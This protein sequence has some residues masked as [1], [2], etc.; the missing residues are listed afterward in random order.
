MDLTN[1]VAVVTGA[2]RGLGRQ[3][4]LQLLER[5]AKVYAAAR[6]PE[7]IDVPGAIPLRID[8]TDPATIEAATKTAAD[9]TLVVNNAAASTKEQL[10]TGD[11]DALRLEME[12]NY[13]GTLSMVRAFVPAIERNGG[14][15]ILNILSALSW[16]H[17]A[18]DGQTGGSGPAVWAGPAVARR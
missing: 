18:S 14:G 9:A 12:T 13:F 10:L 17:L 6:N 4:T 1:A 11:L 7:S 3:L 2:N 8:L 5:G 15:A 16:L